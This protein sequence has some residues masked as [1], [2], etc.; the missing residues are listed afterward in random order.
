M[1]IPEKAKILYKE[2]AVE[3]QKNLHDE[4]ADLYGQI[5]YLPE[6]I[7]LN[8]DSSEEQ[9]KATLIHELIHGMDEMFAIGL[10]EKQ[11]EKLG[12]ALYMLIKD[13]PD[14]FERSDDT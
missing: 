3:Q 8:A 7:F 10:K 2:Y 4:G 12:N 11:V 5:H 14:M 6:S 1:T 13:N 9:K